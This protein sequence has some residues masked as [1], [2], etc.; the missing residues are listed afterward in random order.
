MAHFGRMMGIRVAKKLFGGAASVLEL[1]YGAA[2][3]VAWYVAY[4]VDGR[5]RQAEREPPKS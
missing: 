1:A 3:H 4:Q 5:A 2:R